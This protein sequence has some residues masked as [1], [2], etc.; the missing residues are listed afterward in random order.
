MYQFDDPDGRRRNIQ[1]QKYF[2]MVILNAEIP[3]FQNPSDHNL[4]SI[5]N[6]PLAL[7]FC[8]DLQW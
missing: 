5:N 1:A 6:K 8:L 3:I 2:L 7:I 4:W